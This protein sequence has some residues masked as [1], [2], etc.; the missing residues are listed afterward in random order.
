MKLGPILCQTPN[1]NST[2]KPSRQMVVLAE[3]EAHQMRAGY[4]ALGTRFGSFPR[5]GFIV[6]HL[7]SR[8]VA[9]FYNRWGTAE[10]WIKEA[11]KRRT[12]HGCRVSGSGQRNPV[13]IERSGVQPWQSLDGS[14]C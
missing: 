11:D 8:A 7:P 10:R 6:I 1:L 4:V 13:A 2:Y 3:N 12:G 9:R 5:V 14:W